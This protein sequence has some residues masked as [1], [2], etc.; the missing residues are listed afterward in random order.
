MI[1]I[2]AA[3]KLREVFGNLQ[4]AIYEDENVPE[5]SR[6]RLVG[7]ISAEAFHLVD[8]LQGVTR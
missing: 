3:N 2:E 1:D 6:E 7:L 4:A 8:E 5:E